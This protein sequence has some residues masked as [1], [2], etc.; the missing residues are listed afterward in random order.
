MSRRYWYPYFVGFF[1]LVASFGLAHAPSALAQG[2]PSVLWQVQPADGAV[3]GAAL[4][5]D[6]QHLVAVLGYGFD[7]G[8]GIVSF[9]PATG[10]QRWTVPVPESPSADPVIA[11]GVVYAGVGSLV[12]DR[13]AVY[14]LDIES[15]VQLWRTDVSNPELPATPVDGVT[16]TAGTVFVNR[17]DG[18]L[19]ALDAADGAERWS[20]RFERPQRGAPVTDGAMVYVAT[21]F[22]GAIILALDAA[23]GEERWRSSQP[24]NPVTGPVVADGQLIVGFTDGT[25]VAFD[26]ATGEE[27]WRALAGESNDEDPSPPW[28]GLPVVV[29][30]SLYVSSNGF[31]GART[32]AIDA[33]T[34]AVAWSADTGGFSTSAPALAGDTLLVGSDSGDL[35]G[36]DAATGAE[37]WRVV[38]PDTI[39]TGLD[40]ASPPLV[41]G[42]R[43]VVTTDA[44]GIVALG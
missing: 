22:D 15:G 9:D 26:A 34:G 1:L 3:V 39:D 41:G 11:G 4:S 37:R 27:R 7:P 8:G 25:L 30:G 21:G 35:I 36:L 38:I 20:V 43:I 42:G 6:G 5:S 17:G 19:L 44:G 2:A 28:P 14:A 31:S 29:D 32:L 12:S 33:E 16:S 24:A 18:V 40:Q 23:T 10:E 13:S